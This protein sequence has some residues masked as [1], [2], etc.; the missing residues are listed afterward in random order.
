MYYFF[1]FIK[2]LLKFLHKLI[3]VKLYIIFKGINFIGV[4]KP[5]SNLKPSIITNIYGYIESISEDLFKIF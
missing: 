3:K 5:I 1:I 4:L 2:K